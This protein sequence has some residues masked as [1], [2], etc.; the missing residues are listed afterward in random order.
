MLS[1]YDDT[2]TSEKRELELRL[3]LAQIQAEY[4]LKMEWVV[5]DKFKASQREM[6][7]RWF[8][9]VKYFRGEISKLV[10]V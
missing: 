4:S 3:E 8:E 6:T 1:E 9:R 7:N 2:P 5:G 10:N